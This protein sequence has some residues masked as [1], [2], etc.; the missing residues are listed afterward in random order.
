MSFYLSIPEKYFLQFMN[1][2]KDHYVA[3]CKYLIEKVMKQ[4]LWFDES[5]EM[6]KSVTCKK[7][8]KLSS[9][10]FSRQKSTYRYQ[11]RFAH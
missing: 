3:G 8:K 10:N 5:F 1:S 2:A 6:F 11:R 9:Y 7:Q 4:L